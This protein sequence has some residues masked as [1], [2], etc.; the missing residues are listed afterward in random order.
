[1]L[2]NLAFLLSSHYRPYTLVGALH[3]L[4]HLI[5][6]QKPYKAGHLTD[7]QSEAQRSKNN[8]PSS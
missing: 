4:F 5:L 3:I 6:M 8:S 1:M 7:V 2:E